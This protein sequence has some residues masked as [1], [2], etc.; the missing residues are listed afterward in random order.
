MTTASK[1]FELSAQLFA[2]YQRIIHN[3]DET[4]C[5][6]DQFTEFLVDSPLE[7]NFFVFV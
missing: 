7:V 2:K 1:T 6:A 5:D 3:D 4:E